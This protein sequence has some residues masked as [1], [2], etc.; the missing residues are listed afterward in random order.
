MTD[1]P[2]VIDLFCGCG[3]FSLSA[4]QAGFE[5]TTSVDKDA[6][7]TSSYRT[8][9]PNSNL[10]IADISTLSGTDLIKLNSGIPDGIIGGPPCQGFSMI[11]KRQE[12]DI[13][14]ELLYHFFRLVD[15]VKPKFFIMENVPGIIS[16]NSADYL[17]KN[18]DLVSNQYELLPTKVFDA[19][20][21]GAATKRKRV[22]VI[23][24]RKADCNKPD[25]PQSLPSVSV[26]QAISD[27]PNQSM[28]SIKCSDFMFGRYRVNPSE[29]ASEMRLAPASELGSPLAKNMMSKGLVSGCSFTIH[30]AEVKK[31]FRSL[32]QGETDKISR[33][34]KL[35]WNEPCNTLRAGTGKDAG[36]FQAARPIHPYQSRVINVR[37]AARLQGFPDWFL[38]HPTTWHSFR[39][40]GNS[41]APKLGA[42]VLTTMFNS[43]H[44]K[45]SQAA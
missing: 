1:L 30:T 10:V 24:Y 18:I 26:N 44:L 3:G 20:S 28:Q 39:M 37:E 32:K 38:F 34:L 35:R 40:I 13:R 9:F 42:A 15:E 4:K 23:G 6:I 21:Y 29:Y 14:N 16:G 33:Y 41:V 11:G 8:N 27:L 17:S 25:D 2:T 5:V 22:F 45:N 12:N 36:S 43:I 19:S 7:L 31:R